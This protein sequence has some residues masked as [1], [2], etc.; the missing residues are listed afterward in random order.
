MLGAEASVLAGQ[1]L[2]GVGDVAD[3]HLRGREGD[4]RGREGLG[5]GF[6]AG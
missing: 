1:D 6:I 4:F 2:A 3:H 5:L